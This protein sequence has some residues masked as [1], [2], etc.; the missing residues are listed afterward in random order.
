MRQKARVLILIGILTSSAKGQWPSRSDF[1]HDGRWEVQL[2]LPDLAGAAQ[3]CTSGN[4]AAG[5]RHL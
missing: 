5:V 4:P 2:M 3:L 1:H